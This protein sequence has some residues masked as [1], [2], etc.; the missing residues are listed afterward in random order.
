MEKYWDMRYKFGGISGSGSVG[1]IRADKWVIMD[2]YI[3]NIDDIIDV[4]CGDLVFWGNRMP[5][6]YTGIDISSY[7]IE[8]NQE[9]Y[10]DKLFI[11]SPAQIRL[12]LPPTKIVTCM[13][14]LQ[15]IMNDKIFEDIIYNL[16]HYSSKWIFIHTWKT[17]PLRP[18]FTDYIY[19]MYHEPDKYIDIIEE[20]GFKL[21]G[22]YSGGR[23]LHIDSA[24][25][26]FK[27]VM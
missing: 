22:S 6:N 7:R 18:L 24:L 26:V 21:M 9:L 13:D 4:G 14:V 17:N 10:P 25:F 15:H 23:K 3:D 8:K 5:K 20:E 1:K 2:K 11:T 19:Q 16:I 12:D 27:K